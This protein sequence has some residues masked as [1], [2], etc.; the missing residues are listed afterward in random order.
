[1]KKH[2]LLSFWTPTPRQTRTFSS[3]G[4][5]EVNQLYEMAFQSDILL[6]YGG[7]GTGKTSLIQCGL[8]NKFQEYDWLALTIRRGTD[9]NLSLIQTLR[10]AGGG[11]LDTGESD[12]DELFNESLPGAKREES[13][14][15]LYLRKVYLNHFRPIYLIFDQFEELYILGSRSEQ[16][17]FTST[18]QV[19]LALD[20]PVKIIL[21]IREEYLGHLY[22]FEKSIPHLLRK[23]IRR[24]YEP[25][26][27]ETNHRRIG[28]MQNSL[29]KVSEKDTEV[30]S[31]L[32]LEK[33]KG[34]EDDWYSTALPSGVFG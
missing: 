23:K 27:G 29:V 19:I 11:I 21:S 12:F 31:E 28:A 25:R 2:I 16:E 10:Q 26:K 22:D 4:M 3:E 24:A 13:E 9:I 18:I 34:E 14:L 30:F 8:A 20:Q 15:A 17:T 6:V 5:R 33:I 7:S 32:L 1:M